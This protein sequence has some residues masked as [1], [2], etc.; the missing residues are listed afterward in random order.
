MKIVTGRNAV[1]DNFHAGGWVAA[2]DIASGRLGPAT[3][4]GLK[5]PGTWID[6]HPVTG[7]HI[8]GRLLPDWHRVMTLVEE[9]HRHFPDR[10]G[11]GWDVAMTPTGPCIVE[12][13]LQW[14][15]DMVQRTHRQPVG[16]SRFAQTYAHHVR[17]ALA[18]LDAGTAKKLVARGAGIAAPGKAVPTGRPMDFWAGSRPMTVFWMAWGLAV[19]LLGGAIAT[20]AW[21]LSISESSSLL[22]LTLALATCAILVIGAFFGSVRL[23]LLATAA[24]KRVL[25][26]NLAIVIAM[27]LKELR[28]SIKAR[29]DSLGADHSASA[30]TAAPVQ[31]IEIPKFFGKREEIRKLLGRPTERTLQDILAG[32]Q[33]YNASVQELRSDLQA[34]D[35]EAGRHTVSSLQWK[36]RELADQ[37]RQA[38]SALAPFHRAAA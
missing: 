17:A 31:A 18:A 20:A 26:Q 5:Q 34:P 14:G 36:S 30:A 1:V 23:A 37:I 32:L 16:D 11:I 21:L 7:A 29:A 15:L 24:L 13:N 2:V 4:S 38:I 22:P 33:S 8:T 35:H 9:A 27:E 3:D 19:L 10:V 12:A 28:A 25:A 6:R